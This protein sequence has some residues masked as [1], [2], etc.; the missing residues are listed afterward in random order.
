MNA[1]TWNPTNFKYMPMNKSDRGSKSIQLQNTDTKRAVKLRT[2]LMMTW[3][4][5]D[6]SIRPLE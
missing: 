5:Q 6:F 4:I 2:T 1:T 3:G